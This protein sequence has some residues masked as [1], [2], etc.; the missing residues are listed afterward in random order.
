M[1]LLLNLILNLVVMKIFDL[2]MLL[3]KYV[4]ELLVMRIV[5]KLALFVRRLCSVALAVDVF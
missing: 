5:W 3:M 1:L 2:L 4:V